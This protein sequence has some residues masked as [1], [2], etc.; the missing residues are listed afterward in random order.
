MYLLLPTERIN[1][2]KAS[3]VHHSASSRERISRENGAPGFSGHYFM[4]SYIWS[5]TLN[6]PSATTEESHSYFTAIRVADLRQP[7]GMW[8]SNL[9]KANPYLQNPTCSHS[10]KT[11]T[12]IIYVHCWH[13]RPPCN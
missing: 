1:F 8:L 10:T 5:K 3:P 4:H 7:R 6:T 11:Q 2:Y 9:S 13:S 12:E